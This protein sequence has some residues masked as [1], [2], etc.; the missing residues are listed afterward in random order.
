MVDTRQVT[1]LSILLGTNRIRAGLTMRPG[2]CNRISP[3][4]TGS[5]RSSYNTPSQ[6]TENTMG[7]LGISGTDQLLL[8]ATFSNVP[9]MGESQVMDDGLA[10]SQQTLNASLI[11][12][13]ANR[14]THIRS[15]GNV[16]GVNRAL[17]ESGSENNA[18]E[19]GPTSQESY[20]G[21][22]TLRDLDTDA[23][24]PD[25][26]AN[27]AG[28]TALGNE[29]AD[30]DEGSGAT[31]LES[32]TSRTLRGIKMMKRTVSTSSVSSASDGLGPT[33][34]SG[35]RT[36]GAVRKADTESG[37][38]T[39]IQ[40]ESK[41]GLQSVADPISNAYGNAAPVAFGSVAAALSP[42]DK[43]QQGKAA[44]AAAYKDEA[45][46]GVEISN[47]GL[48]V[49]NKVIDT[50]HA[51]KENTTPVRGRLKTRPLPV[52]E[53][54]VS[55]TQTTA[56]ITPSQSQRTP[57]SEESTQ[58]SA[59]ERS[60]PRTLK[61]EAAKKPATAKHDSPVNAPKSNAEKFTSSRDEAVV[62]K[63]LKTE[64]FTNADPETKKRL[65]Q[66]HEGEDASYKQSA[67]QIQHSAAENG[68][69]T[70]NMGDN[71]QIT[72]MSPS[73]V[74]YGTTT[75]KDEGLSN[76][77]DLP[78][79]DRKSS[80][81]VSPRTAKSAAKTIARGISSKDVKRKAAPAQNLPAA[82][83]MMETRTS[84]T[85]KRA[86]IGKENA[87]L[88]D[89]DSSTAKKSVKTKKAKETLLISYTGKRQDD[90]EQRLR[91]AVIYYENGPF[92]FDYLD[93]PKEESLTHL[94]A[95]LEIQRPTLK[96]LYA[97]CQG[98]F[99]LTPE[100]LEEAEK[101]EKWPSEIGFEHPKWPL[102]ATRMRPLDLMHDLR[103]FAPK[104]GKKL[105]LEDITGLITL[106]GGQMVKSAAEAT[107][108]LIPEGTNPSQIIAEKIP[109]DVTVVTENWLINVIER[110]MLLPSDLRNAH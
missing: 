58:G 46:K 82:T 61:T 29:T 16:P 25:I 40:G 104:N 7:T 88:T 36:K 98:A 80:T 105:G 12:Q 10:T 107:H 44:T 23:S 57:I 11:T 42:R 50:G 52:D 109:K 103:I 43:V 2:E 62:P 70:D 59:A 45:T 6:S 39:N 22:L 95:P 76:I 21:A 27:D 92:V 69:T 81:N 47:L 75:K 108:C 35:L 26:C 56:D 78:V 37:S 83:E 48:A 3:L 38:K 5:L 100:Y 20:S 54:S 84:P 30:V 73:N 34:R 51:L 102:R 24:L 89:K 31:E 106:C 32:T 63:V 79:T 94:I 93:S 28:E 68:K 41:L 53:S 87:K 99:I 65:I 85:Q 13:A 72:G 86:K 71:I 19:Q 9:S 77:G 4:G 15:Q 64:N 74:G 67:H 90:I 110:M 55:A 91:K 33:R 101:N 49:N 97:I 96:V 18:S 8:S 17:T 14:L 1:G 60:K 66:F